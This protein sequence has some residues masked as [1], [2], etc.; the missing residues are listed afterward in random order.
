MQNPRLPE[1]I[2][3]IYG[4][5]VPATP[6]NDLT[7][8]FLQ[9]I[10]KQNAGLCGDPS[11]V[12]PVDLNS[13]GLNSDVDPNAIVPSEMLRLNMSVPVTANPNRLGVL[14]GD[15]QG[16]PNG[17]RLTDD[18]VDIEVQAVEGAAQTGKLVDGLKTIDSVDRNDRDVRGDVPVRRAAARRQREHGHRAHAAGA[19]VVSI[20][21]TRV[22]ETRAPSRAAR[23]ATRA[24]SRPMARTFASRSPARARSRR[25]LGRGAQRHRDERARSTAWSPPTRAARR[26]RHVELQPDARADHRRAW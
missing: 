14:A 22:L 11:T 8:I 4:V 1:L 17:R 7:E 10:S 6:R 26:G 19:R 9:G 23:S 21:P 24:P 18:V 16:F 2:N 15:V 5:P 25:R 3:K 13:P 12:L 20:N